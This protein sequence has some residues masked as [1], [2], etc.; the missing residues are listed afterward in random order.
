[1]IFGLLKA[2]FSRSAAFLLEEILSRCTNKTNELKEIPAVSTGGQKT[3]T[4]VN[5][6]DIHRLEPSMLQQTNKLQPILLQNKL[7]SVDAVY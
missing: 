7:G 5:F 4:V 2:V 1:M 6:S 3:E